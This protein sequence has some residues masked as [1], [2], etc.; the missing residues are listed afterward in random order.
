MN[1]AEVKEW[2]L[3]LSINPDEVQGQILDR[4]SIMDP[5]HNQPKKLDD[6]RILNQLIHQPINF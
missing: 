3:Q 1:S 5:Q 6:S 2:D 4:P